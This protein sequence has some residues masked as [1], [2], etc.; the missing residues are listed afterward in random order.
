MLSVTSI[1]AFNDNYIWL[2]KNDDNHCVV[3]DPGDAAPVLSTL[4]QMKLTLD[5][6][7]V[8]H[9]H[10]DHIGGIQQLQKAFPDLTIYGPDSDRFP[11]VTH[12]LKDGDRFTLFNTLFTTIQVPGHTLDHIAYYAEGMLFSGDT[13]FS[14]GCGRLFEG[15]PTQMHQSL[16]RLASL[17]DDTQVFCAHEYTLSNLEF[18][19]AVEPNNIALNDYIIDAKKV[20]AKNQPTLPSSIGLEKR[21]N[22][23]LRSHIDSVKDAVVQRASDLTDI[24]TFAALRRWKDEF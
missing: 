15:T 16:T 12:P 4:N 7:L 17:P 10:H 6:V 8:T 21:I 18:A 5:G 2:L 24:E 20:R 19:H 13:L 14:G 23:F 11:M 22:P 3:V 1:P 9:H